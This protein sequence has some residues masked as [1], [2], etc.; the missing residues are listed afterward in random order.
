M[1]TSPVEWIALPCELIEG[2]TN[3]VCFLA[4]GHVIVR[5]EDD[6]D[7]IALT[8]RQ[9]LELVALAVQEGFIDRADLYH[10]T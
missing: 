7:R 6:E 9:L 1:I 5:D 3:I 4:S 2:R 10:L 8:R